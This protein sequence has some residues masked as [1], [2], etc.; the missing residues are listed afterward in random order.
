M[1]LNL[2]FYTMKKLLF[3]CL[4]AIMSTSC[5]VAM[6]TNSAT[7]EKP[8]TAVVADLDVS[9]TKI[10]KIYRPTTNVINGGY[11]NVVNTAIR[12]AL[13]ENGDADVLVGLETQA[14]F[15][16]DGRV[17][18]IIITGYPAKYVNFRNASDEHLSL[19]LTQSNT[20]KS[21][22]QGKLKLFQ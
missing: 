21:K 11:D 18:S 12:E 7:Q 5:S 4:V 16:A 1:A 8:I 20:S 13:Y 19:L 22:K 15:N 14:K 3:G 2:N 17:E 10:T 9:P 6:L